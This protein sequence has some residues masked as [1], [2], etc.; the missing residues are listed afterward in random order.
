MSGCRNCRPRRPSRRGGGR[1]AVLPRWVRLG[2]GRL[3]RRLDVLHPV[4]L[5][6]HR[7]LVRERP[8]ADDRL[9]RFW[10]AV[11]PADAGA[12]VALP[13]SRLGLCA[14][15]AEQ[16]E[17]PRPTRSRPWLR[18]P[19]GGSSSPTELRRPVPGARARCCT[20][21]RWR[22]RS[23]STSSS[24]G[25]LGRPS[26]RGRRRGLAV[27]VG[28]RS[29]PPWSSRVAQRPH[30]QRLLR[31]PHP[32]GRDACRRPPR[33]L[34]VG[35]ARPA[36]RRHARAASDDGRTL[37]AVADGVGAV[38]LLAMF[39]AWYWSSRPP[40]SSPTAASRSTPS[41]PRSSSTPPPGR[42]WCRSSS[43]S[44]SCAGPA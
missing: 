24:P 32:G 23:S 20:S 8:R 9:G 40:P 37:T 31:H 28:L 34:V 5:P 11:P 43:R 36:P 4:G 19:T 6:H 13:S 21:G 22:S 41:A 2:E 35:T 12:L 7:L 25:R 17:A 27:L 42:A 29:S 30:D 18:A 44:R 10:P 26:A 14:S 15:P 1:R 33:R 16:L 38:A 3:P 39:G